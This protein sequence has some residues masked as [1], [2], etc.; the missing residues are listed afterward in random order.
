MENLQALQKSTG[1]IESGVIRRWLSPPDPSANFNKAREQHHIGTGQWFLDSD[2]YSKWK[3]D[4]NSFLWL[5]GIPGCGK[6]ILSSSV[7]ADLEKSTTFDSLIYFYFDFKDIEKQSLEKAVRSLVNQLYYKREDVRTEVDALYRLCDEGRR[8]PNTSML[9]KLFQDMLHKVGEAWLILD[10]LDECYL[11]DDSF[12]NGLLPWIKRIRECGV[13]VHTLVTSRPEYDIKAAIEGWA[14]DDEIIP[15]QNSRVEVDIVVYIKARTKQVDRWQN[16]PDIQKEI[17]DAL[18]QKANG[19]FRWV[20]CQFD[21]LTHCFDRTAIRRELANLPR[22]LDATY[23]RILSRVQPEYIRYTTR[24]LQFLA[25]SERPLRLDEAVDVLAVDTSNQPRFDAANR[26]VI[27]EKI[28]TYCAGL[29]ILVKRQAEDNETTVTEI[30]LAHV[31]VQEYLTSGRLE[32]S[33]AND[34]QET[35]ARISI[36]NVCLSY[37]LDI[38]HLY[39][40]SE[41][42]QKYPLA[43]YSARYWAQNAA[44][45]ESLDKPVAITKEYFSLRTAF[46]FGYQLYRPDRPWEEEPDDLGE[47]VTCLYYTSVCGLLYSTRELLEK[48]AD[49]NAQGGQYGNALQAASSRG[50]KEIVQALLEKGA[51]VN[52]QG[53]RYGN[54]LQAASSRGHKEIVQAL[55]EKG[56]DV[57]AQGG[58]YGNTLQAA[59]SR[60]HKEIVQALL[61]KGAVVNAQG[62]RYGNA[63]QAVSFG[64]YKEIVQTLLEKGAD[65]NAQGGQYGNALQAASFGGYKEIVQT[66]LEKGADVNAQGGQYGNALQAASF[67]GYKEI[68]QTLLEKGADVNAQGGGLGNALYAA[69]FRGHKAVVRL[70]LDKGADTTAAANDGQ[71]PL[72]GASSEGHLEVAKL[73]IE[74][75]AD[76]NAQGGVYGNALQAAVV[77][78]H[79]A[80]VRLLAEKGTDI[81][82]QGGHYGNAL[83]AASFGGYESIVQFL[84]HMHAGVDAQGGYYH[85]ALQ[86]AS[87]KGHKKIVQLLLEQNVNVRGKDTEGHTALSLAAENGH[88]SIVELL[89]CTKGVNSNVMDKGGEAPLSLAAKNGH[90]R[91]VSLLLKDGMIESKDQYG[92]TA[93]LYAAEAAH[94]AVVKLLLANGANINIR[95]EHSGTALLY[96]AAGG[97]ETT[98]QLLLEQGADIDSKNDQNMSPLTRAIQEGHSLVVK[99]L[100]SEGAE[101]D[102]N[103][104]NQ[105]TP[106]S[107]AAEGGHEEIAKLLFATRRI[108]VNS[109]DIFGQSPFWWAV[110][111]EHVMLVRLFMDEGS[112]DVNVKDIQH[113]ASPLWWSAR[114]GLAAVVSLLLTDNG[115]EVESKDYNYRTPFS[116]AAENGRDSVIR[117]LL[118]SGKVKTGYQDRLYSRTA[119]SYAAGGGHDTTVK[120]LLAFGTADLN[121]VDYLGRTPLSIAA[122]N[123]HHSVVELLLAVGGIIPDHADKYRGTPLMRASE[124]GHSTIVHLLLQRDVKINATDT[125]NGRTPL[126]WAVENEHEEVCS[127]LLATKLTL[128]ELKDKTGHTALSLAAWNGCGATAQLLINSG[129]SLQSRDN[130]KRVPLSWASENGHETVARLL[131]EA[132]ADV[133]SQDDKFRTPL[134]WAS[135]NGHE[136]VARLLVEAG[137]DVAS[138]DDK[139]RTPLSWASENGHETV[140]RLLVEAGADV[141]SQDDKFR[142][143]LS[144]ASENGHEAVARLLV[145]AGADVASQDD[146][147]RTPLSWASENGHEAVARLLVET[148]ADVA[149]QDD[150]CRTP[151]SWASE[152][153]HEAVARLLVEAGADVDSTD[154]NGHLPLLHAARK[155]YES[156][157]KLLLSAPGGVH[158]DKCGTDGRSAL[159]WAAGNGH[160]TIVRLLLTTKKVNA[161]CEDQDGLTALSWAAR[162]GRDGILELLMKSV[163]L[164]L[165]SKSYS[166]LSPLSWASRYGHE[167]AVKLLLTNPNVDANT[168]DGNGWTP[169]AWAVSRRHVKIVRM[170]L[171]HNSVDKNTKDKEGRSLLSLALIHHDP[172]IVDL[173]STKSDSTPGVSDDNRE[174]SLNGAPIRH[175]PLLTV[176]S[177]MQEESSNHNLMEG[178]DTILG[179]ASATGGYSTNKEETPRHT[180]EGFVELRRQL[181]YLLCHD[182]QPVGSDNCRVQLRVT[183]E[184]YQAMRLYKK[185]ASFA[186]IL[187]ISGNEVD[188]QAATCESYL[189]EHFESGS[190]VI[191]AIQLAWESGSQCITDQYNRE[192]QHLSVEISG[193]DAEMATIAA[194]GSSSI[195]IDVACAFAWFCAAIRPIPSHS[196][197]LSTFAFSCYARGEPAGNSLVNVDLNLLFRQVKPGDSCWHGLF[198]R[199]MI[200]LDG[201]IS[202]REQ[203]GQ[204]GTS[205]YAL[206]KGLD[207][208][209]NVMLE[210]AAINYPIEYDRGV[211]LKGFS[212]LL[213]TTGKWT[214]GASTAIQWHF[215]SSCHGGALSKYLQ[216]EKYRVSELGETG[217]QF[218]AVSKASRT[219]VGWGNTHEIQLHKV[220]LSDVKV[221]KLDKV[222]NVL[223]FKS[224]A[225]NIALGK[226][227]VTIGAN[228]T[229]EIQRGSLRHGEETQFHEMIVRAGLNPVLLYA[230]EEGRGW[231]VPQLRVLECMAHINIQ[232]YQFSDRLPPSDLDLPSCKARLL[233]HLRHPVLRG[234]LDNDESNAN[235]FRLR[236]L[237][238]QLAIFLD[239]AETQALCQ[240]IWDPRRLSGADT[241]YGLDFYKLAMRHRVHDLKKYQVKRPHGKWV[242]LLND[243]MI[244]GVIFCEGL[245]D[246]I[247]CDSACPSC[248][249]V[250]PHHNYLAAVVSCLEYLSEQDRVPTGF[251]WKFRSASFDQC[252]MSPSFKHHVQAMVCKSTMETTTSTDYTGGVVV[253]G[254]Y[255]SGCKTSI[256]SPVTG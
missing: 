81:N 180:G 126:M 198:E 69:S 207:V 26:T 117:L 181:T 172:E 23:A 256:D 67:G 12:A 57:N 112:V 169:L 61:E 91:V 104:Y 123:G 56:A 203:F 166:G 235:I 241:I 170:L 27:P 135:E 226:A 90:E 15:L 237:L 240:S 218:E 10:A 59:S 11:R 115:L 195:L 162:N 114:Q 128:L 228:A 119:L 192:L 102:S 14:Y 131:V 182:D 29:V 185:G 79:E 84:L 225:I 100:L 222:E 210:I 175:N 40:I 160:S 13:N 33:I 201:P 186:S 64:G 22:T 190:T 193:S 85:T 1:D 101:P 188:A 107:F 146:K 148:G 120:L 108:D 213:V 245:G 48:G 73:L 94:D 24:L 28:V 89:L 118:N 139:F 140:A 156:I 36:V 214:I 251:S 206:P 243:G 154:K 211:I 191:Q 50:H 74:K 231:L 46:E 113:Q 144:W 136:A 88:E 219:F 44:V 7:V 232:K 142:T 138:Q 205:N 248:R 147:F 110:R 58:R 9:Y 227:P 103:G 116:V 164:D 97:H 20:S 143:P 165:N 252:S 244:K 208:Q 254:E 8:Q 247:I 72:H 230:P 93:L 176:G 5:N 236:E 6:T 177:K 55:L 38:D 215:D 19:M 132:G 77:N 66:L 239:W 87:Y 125:L 151:L 159:S 184:V 17:E 255:E 200:V 189:R 37:L 83:Q 129:A 98:V 42:R 134:S 80:I 178:A 179:G 47:L 99:L 21:I 68:V 246:V 238:H 161:S 49:V 2:Q 75:G 150:N 32:G 78:G 224:T 51:V 92:G 52:A 53:G 70:L 168:Q 95:D 4:R 196:L 250:P 209:F 204:P 194:S 96:A 18:V 31:S 82:A 183:W 127:L 220:N 173:I 62:G 106:L 197:S 221:T 121:T 25:Y 216:D 35:T 76:V 122:A 187:T 242:D 16:R 149:S 130:H 145:E 34:L 253:F 109:R 163:S 202:S 157:V 111:Y 54:A 43:Q 41:A 212:T 233:E 39:T 133:A 153:G 167:N 155:G 60:G 249:M 63:L 141:A 124:N 105:R 3:T 199:T 217:A 30:Q 65:V 174:F 171:H 229:F 137:A 234:M 45:I 223:R 71:R 158:C 86:A 152:N